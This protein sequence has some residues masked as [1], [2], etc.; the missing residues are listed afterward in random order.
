VIAALLMMRD[1]PSRDASQP[2]EARLRAIREGLRFVF[3]N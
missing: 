1:V 3:A 2:A